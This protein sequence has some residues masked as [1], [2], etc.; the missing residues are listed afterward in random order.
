MRKTKL[1]FDWIHF[2][3]NNRAKMHSSLECAA[4]AWSATEVLHL[5]A[6]EATIIP[7]PLKHG[8]YET[9]LTAVHCSNLW[10]R[11]RTSLQ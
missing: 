7:A 8:E 10:T 3:E 5:H 9:I 4:S 11:T 1:V 2:Q 6:H